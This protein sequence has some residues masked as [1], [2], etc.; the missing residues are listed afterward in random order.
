[1]AYLCALVL[2]FASFEVIDYSLPAFAVYLFC[3][4]LLCMAA[5]WQEAISSNSVLITH[6]LNA[7]N[8][9][10]SMLANETLVFLIGAGMGI[11][12]N[13]HLHS[14]ESDFERLAGNVDD[15]I[16]GILRRMSQWIGKQDKKEYQSDCFKQLEEAT[17]A[18]K[19]CAAANY[20]NSFFRK[21]TYELD[22]IR[23]RKQ[24]TV[25][26][27]GI[28]KNIK[29]MDYLPDQAEQI[30]ELFAQV[31]QAYHKENTVEELLEGLRMLLEEMK[32]EKL[33]ESREEF[34]ARAIL[35]YI[36]TQ[37][38]ELL[39]IKRRFILERNKEKRKVW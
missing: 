12:V 35:F 2:A 5:G 32:K 34:E 26:L 8:M 20:N 21:D 23:M 28:Y 33:P 38:E 11:L 15:Q 13:L 24:Q 17:R 30:A 14:K 39:Q 29:R 31:E 27:K 16:K 19:L 36:L 9:G 18:A 3:F 4:A 37:M 1:M 22:Y 7:G 25:V 10:L 6:F